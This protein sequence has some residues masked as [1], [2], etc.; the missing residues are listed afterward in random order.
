LDI[1]D[2][3]GIG[4]RYAKFLKG[5]GVLTAYDFT[6]KSAWWVKKGMGVV[7]LRTQ[8]ELKGII[9]Q[10]ID[11]REDKKSITT[12]RS[13]GEMVKEYEDLESAVSCFAAACA[14]K[15]RRQKTVADCIT[16]YVLTNFYREDL[17]KYYNSITL[18]LDEA[19]DSTIEIVENAI[20]GLKK[21]FRKGYY[22]KKAGVIVSD[23]CANNSVQQNLFIHK[24]IEKINNLN[25][26]LDNVNLKY[27]KD[28]L[29][30]AVQG[31]FNEKKEKWFMK[32]EGLSGN[33]TTD[34]KDIIIVK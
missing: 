9:A 11:Y 2:V 31:G 8:M 21:I 13:F 3:W 33:F 6:I 14:E 12:S 15:L 5:E 10:K 16:V 30:I 32:R 20:A 25:K 29:K 26:V 18:K 4:R 17:E 24:D 27:G 1:N 28:T 22:Y 7:G 23:I 34:L 19:T